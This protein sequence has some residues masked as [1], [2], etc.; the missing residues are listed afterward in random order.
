MRL[1]TA[2]CFTGSFAEGRRMQEQNI[3]HLEAL[4]LLSV[5]TVAYNN[6]S[7]NC[8]PKAEWDHHL[9]YADRG[10]EIAS[11]T[12]DVIFVHHFT[13]LRGEDAF[14]RGEWGQARA[15]W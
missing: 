8:Y 14:F 9:Y 2:T 10:F 12:G 11:R 3:A 4:D 13:W 5:L 15:L 1:G 7:C 6:L